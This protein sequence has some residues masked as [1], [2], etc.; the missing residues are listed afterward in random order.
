VVLPGARHKFDV[1]DPRRIE[2]RWVSKTREGCPLELDLLQMAVRDRRSGATVPQAQVAALVRELCSEKGASIEGDRK[3]RDRA[4]QA[5]LAFLK[6]V[7]A[8]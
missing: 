3:S 5:V 1:D 6:K 8:P 4:A 7:F 2:L